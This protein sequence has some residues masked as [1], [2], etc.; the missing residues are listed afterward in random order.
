MKTRKKKS[1]GKRVLLSLLAIVL[2]LLCYMAWRPYD[3]LPRPF[4]YGLYPITQDVPGVSIEAGD[5]ILTDRN[6]TV[7]EGK[8]AV[9]PASGAGAAEIAVAVQTEQSGAE[10]MAY[11]IVGLGAL[12]LFLAQWRI[13]V[14]GGCGLLVVVWVVYTL[15]SKQRRLRKKQQA[16]RQTFAFYGEKYNL[17]DSDV[18]Y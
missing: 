2:L 8:L 10:A 12:V 6:A 9:F 11:R 13:V 4:G 18:E 3:L 16:L 14:W 7:W 17:E 1:T 15:C 5:A